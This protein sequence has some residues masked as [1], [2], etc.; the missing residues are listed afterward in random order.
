[1]DERSRT[2]FFW[3]VT[4]ENENAVIKRLFP[5]AGYLGEAV[6]DKAEELIKIHSE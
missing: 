1:M 2:P 6:R 5:D 3:K 4:H